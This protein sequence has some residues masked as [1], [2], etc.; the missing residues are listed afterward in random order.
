LIKHPDFGH[1]A[2]LSYDFILCS[3]P[4]RGEFLVSFSWG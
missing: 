1:K 2:T 4:F 3:F